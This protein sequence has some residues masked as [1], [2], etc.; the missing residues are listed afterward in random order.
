M[1]QTSLHE[2]AEELRHKPALL[3]VQTK[4]AANPQEGFAAPK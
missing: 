4:V 3:A 2:I 1:T